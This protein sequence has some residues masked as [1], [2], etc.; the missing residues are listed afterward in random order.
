MVRGPSRAAPARLPV[1]SR[2]G[3]TQPGDARPGGSLAGTGNDRHHYG[4]VNEHARPAQGQAAGQQAS[5]QPAQRAVV[6]TH[7][8]RADGLAEPQ[9]IKTHHRQRHRSAQ[10]VRRLNSPTNGPSCGCLPSLHAPYSVGT[11]NGRHPA[12]GCLPAACVADR[13]GRRCGNVFPLRPGNPMESTP[14]LQRISHR[15]LPTVRPSAKGPPASLD[16]PARPLRAGRRFFP[17]RSHTETGDSECGRGRWGKRR[18]PGKCQRLAA[19]RRPW[20]AR[21]GDGEQDRCGGAVLGA[22]VG[23]KAAQPAERV[24]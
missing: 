15:V 21:S 22:E 10:V 20:L 4:Q 14:D 8:H 13:A 19:L 16:V 11:N 2:A 17:S 24:Q 9:R 1:S 7:G 3:A 23:D 6:N 18:L 12:V 5:P